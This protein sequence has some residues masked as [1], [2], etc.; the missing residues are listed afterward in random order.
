MKIKGYEI[1]LTEEQLDD[2]INNQMIDIELISKEF[3]G[4]QNL[5][6]GD[7]KAL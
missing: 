7:K 6:E 5:S 3:P 4:Y 1:A 2:I